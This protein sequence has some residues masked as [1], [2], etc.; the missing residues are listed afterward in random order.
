MMQHF[1]KCFCWRGQCH[2]KQTS[3][4]FPQPNKKYLIAVYKKHAFIIYFFY[5]RINTGCGQKNVKNSAKGIDIFFKNDIIVIA[6]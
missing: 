2:R 4:A 6:V 1:K 5:G 3:T